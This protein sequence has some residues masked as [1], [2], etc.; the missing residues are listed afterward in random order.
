MKGAP[1]SV[2]RKA[3]SPVFEAAMVRA[4]NRQ[5]GRIH[6]AVAA[7]LFHAEGDDATGHMLLAKPDDVATRQAG[8]KQ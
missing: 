4:R 7:V 3:K 8:V 1:R 6:D 2:T 5:H